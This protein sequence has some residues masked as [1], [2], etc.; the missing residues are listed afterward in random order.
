MVYAHAIFHLYPMTTH[1]IPRGLLSEAKKITNI[2][3]SG[4]YFLINDN[5]SEIYVGQTQNGVERLTDHNTKKEFWS[6]AILFISDNHYFNLDLIS[7]LEVYAIKKIKET[8]LF[9]IHNNILP[10]YRIKEY[11]MYNI[12]K[13]FSDIEFIMA[14]SGFPFNQIK[15]E[16]ISS[17]YR[18]SRRGMV[19]FMNYNELGIC[20]VLPGSAIDF[21]INS[22]SNIQNEERERMLKAGGIKVNEE[23]KYILQ[24]AAEFTSPSGAATFVLGGSANGWIEW[25]TTD[26]KTLSEMIRK[27]KINKKSS[28]S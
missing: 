23:G 13:I 18:T 8:N 4:I 7:G 2:T 10:K 22:K 21:S 28:N 14:A 9:T 24:I 26:G 19:A 3:Q 5:L 25:K 6:T 27:T 20:T 12:K 15:K 17:K 1:I 11:D 16:E